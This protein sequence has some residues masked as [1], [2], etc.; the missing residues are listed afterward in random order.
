MLPKDETL[1]L[2]F[3]RPDD[4]PILSLTQPKKEAKTMSNVTPLK[5]TAEA[6]V[7]REKQRSQLSHSEVAQICRLLVQ[8]GSTD[9]EKRLFT[10]AEGW[11]DERIA[12]ILRA[13]PDREHLKPSAVAKVRRRD[14]GDTA[15]ER[16]RD[17]QSGEKSPDVSLRISALET[18]LDRLER[19]LG[20]KS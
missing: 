2:P 13:A 9:D 11:S 17:A 8:H 6:E 12:E 18:R 16:A 5:P 1:S 20:L 7:E 19:E 15:D 10:F 4:R 3:S 14:F